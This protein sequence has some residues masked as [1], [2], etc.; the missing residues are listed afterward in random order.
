MF[1]TIK[2]IIGIV[3]AIAGGLTF[4]AS[5]PEPSIAALFVTVFGCVLVESVQNDR[6]EREDHERWER[7]K[8]VELARESERLRVPEQRAKEADQGW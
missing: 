6:L 5:L 7:Q 4:L 3:L 1:G 2:I 8:Q